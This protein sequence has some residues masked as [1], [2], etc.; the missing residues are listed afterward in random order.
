MAKVVGADGLR[1]PAFG[2]PCTAEVSVGTR[3]K[4]AGG[5]EADHGALPGRWCGVP[6]QYL[7][8]APLRQGRPGPV[9][10][11]ALNCFRRQVAGGGPVYPARQVS[12]YPA[13]LAPRGYDAAQSAR[14]VRPGDGFVQR[15]PSPTGRSRLQSPIG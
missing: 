15:R 12:G 10:R 6:D 7:V 9:G 11:A 1:W 13:W 8:L 4:A 5:E 3:P 14:W 2:L